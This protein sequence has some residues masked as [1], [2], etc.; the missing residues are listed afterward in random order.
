[1][2]YLLMIC[3]DE[4][5][6]ATMTEA[7]MGALMEA[8]G[9]YDEEVHEAGV[10]RDSHR[11]HPI[12]TATTVRV[13]NGKTQTTDGPF[14][15]T[16]EAMGGYYLIDVPSLDE[17]IAWAAKIPTATYGSVEVRPVWEMDEPQ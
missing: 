11:L 17:A 9:K 1:M 16:K 5:G 4:S 14:A 6:Y 12:A 7:D 3:S 10:Y 13:R 8:Y 15:E 2:R